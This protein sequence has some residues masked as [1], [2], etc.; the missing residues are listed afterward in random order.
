MITRKYVHT[1]EKAN[2]APAAGADYIFNTFCIPIA[3][4]Y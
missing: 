1:M 2:F 3:K 4:I